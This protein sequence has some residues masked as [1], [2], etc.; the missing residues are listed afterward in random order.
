M[1]VHEYDIRRF[2]IFIFPK[3]TKKTEKVKQHKQTFYTFSKIFHHSYE[4][5]A[6][7]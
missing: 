2:S 5:T 7:R 6:T 1:Y 3:N 4:N